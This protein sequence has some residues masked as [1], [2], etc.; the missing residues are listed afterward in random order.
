MGH[1][2]ARRFHFPQGTTKHSHG[3]LPA[4]WQ[5]FDGLPPPLRF[6]LHEHP[7]LRWGELKIWGCSLSYQVD[8][9]IGLD[10]GRWMGW[11]YGFTTHKFINPKTFQ[12]YDTTK[13]AAGFALSFRSLRG[14]TNR[15]FLLVRPSDKLDKPGEAQLY[16]LPSGNLLHSYWKM[17]IYSGFTDLP[18]KNGDF[19]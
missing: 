7:E 9:W 4:L 13:I 8:G 11:K 6:A 19:P 12:R 17:A 1:P 5:V 18:I 10:T 16:E 14:S 3:Q 2:T 15:R